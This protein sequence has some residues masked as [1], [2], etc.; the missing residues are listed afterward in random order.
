MKMA[1][2][3]TVVSGGSAVMERTFAGTPMEMVTLYHDKGGKLALTHYCM[4]H[5]RPH[6]VMTKSD[7]K[8]ITLNLDKKGEID[9]KTESHM[10]SLVLTFVGKNE[11]EQLWTHYIDGKAQ[12]PHA[13]RFKRVAK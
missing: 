12:E 10:N 7:K 5:N 13:M 3:Y 11:L 1:L 2:E 9:P 6:L 8:S 4:L